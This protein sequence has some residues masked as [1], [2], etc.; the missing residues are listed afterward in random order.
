MARALTK[1]LTEA[2]RALTESGAGQTSRRDTLLPAPE[3]KPSIPQ[4]TGSSGPKYGN[5]ESGGTGFT[6]HG[7]KTIESTDG[8]FTIYFPK[9]IKARVS[10]EAGGTEVSPKIVTV[11]VI[12]AVDP[13]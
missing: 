4:R 6:L 5:G 2:L 3:A 9:T 7:E 10:G 8:L 12:E 13:T 11:G 1:D